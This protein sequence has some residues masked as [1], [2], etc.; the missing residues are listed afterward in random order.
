M[1]RKIRTD[2]ESVVFEYFNETTVGEGGNNK[3]R[4][5]NL[6]VQVFLKHF[7]RRNPNLFAKLPKLKSDNKSNVFAVDG[8]VGPQT[9]TG[10]RV[11]QQFVRKIVGRGDGFI[12]GRVSVPTG[13]FVPHSHSFFTIDQL[14]SKFFFGEKFNMKFNARLQDHPQ[15]FLLPE[16]HAELST[17]KAEER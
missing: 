4:T 9:I 11:F 1:V 15:V 8:I 17:L 10:I 5:D 3:K 7:Y 12:D 13:V 16:L 14:N 2:D 6:L